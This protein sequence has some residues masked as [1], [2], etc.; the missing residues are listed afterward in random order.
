M[1]STGRPS[2]AS[3]AAAAVVMARLMAVLLLLA[4]FAC[5]SP[6][7]QVHAADDSNSGPL[8]QVPT[9]NPQQLNSA[10]G[11]LSQGT[12][13]TQLQQLISLFQ[14]EMS[15]G[16]Y[17]RAASTL[18]QLKALSASQN[19]SQALNALLQSLSVGGDGASINGTM[20]ASLLSAASSPPFQTG[21]T[22]SGQSKQT[23]SLDMQSLANL[24]QYV[25]GTLASELLQK[26]GLAGPGGSSGSGSS[27]L[28]GN[29]TG[30]AGKAAGASMQPTMA[31]LSWFSGLSMPS[32]DTPS[33]PVGAPSTSV[34]ALP[35]LELAVPLFT[36]AAAIVLFYAR[37]RLMMSKL[38]GA[39]RLTGGPHLDGPGYSDGTDGGT[40]ALA[41]ATSST[42]SPRYVIEFYFGKAVRLM[43]RRGVPKL[44]SETAREFTTKCDGAPERPHVRTISS[45]YEKA[46]FSGQDVVG[47]EASLAATSFHAMERENR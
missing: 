31:G 7:L 32:L 4:V 1:T 37:G 17:T 35:L 43:A 16:N 25:N 41:G 22:S 14:S 45:L 33:L 47:D 29:S 5:L 11:T 23:L 6:P 30:A 2:R 20:L 18:V 15:S 34:S 39:Q 24:L 42:S 40:G 21:T 27:G 46:K 44:E 3:R 13:S 28:L 26:E 38:V 8:T 36:I 10:L 19:N 12:N 9:L